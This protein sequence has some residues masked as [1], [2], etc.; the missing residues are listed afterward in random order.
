MVYPRR[1]L[2]IDRQVKGVGR[3]QRTSGTTKKGEFERRNALITKLIESGHLDTL[4]LFQRGTLTIEQL[5]DADRHGRLLHLSDSL[6]AF[7]PLTP[8]IDEWL[9]DA[10]VKKYTAYGYK[11]VLTRLITVAQ[12]LNQLPDD[13]SIADLE[14]VNWD[15]IHKHWGASEFNWQN[16]H[17]AL[18]SFLSGA[19]NRGLR[20]FR[21][22]VMDRVPRAQLPETLAP[23]LTPAQFWHLIEKAKEEIR[24]ALVTM[25]VLGAGPK[26]YL[27][28]TRDDLNSSTHTV[29]IRGTRERG[30]V[31]V[32]R[33]KRHRRVSV[34][35]RLWPWI[36]KG[37]PSPL[38]YK[39]LREYFLRARS[40][41]ELEPPD[42]EKGITLY[43]LRHL[44]GQAASE[45]GANLQD[46]AQHMGHTQL[47]TTMDYLAGPM[48]RAAAR[49][50][51]DT[52]LGPAPSATESIARP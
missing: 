19:K 23:V 38:R 16:L 10:A 48:A 35:P 28:L 37:V 46:I 27:G 51:A 49:A 34:D 4:R 52:L 6:L 44:S 3:I 24:P 32:K 17:I 21:S 33:P 1:N 45:S 22:R 40:A 9:A 30:A 39:W 8:A 50:I 31:D 47:S 5:V 29:R 13:P 7:A 25:A 11:L 36:D 18:G 20:A 41:A 12:T 15:R 43:T 2:L 42:G 26:E 14:H